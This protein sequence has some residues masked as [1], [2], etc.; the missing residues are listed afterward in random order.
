LKR[1]IRRLSFF[2]I[3]YFDRSEKSKRFLAGSLTIATRYAGPAQFNK[4]SINIKR[5]R[6]YV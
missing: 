4:L 6:M 5:V 2:A 3:P 1:N